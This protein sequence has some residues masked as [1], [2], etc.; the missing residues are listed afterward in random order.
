[1]CDS[2]CSRLSVY[3]CLRSLTMNSKSRIRHLEYEN[4]AHKWTQHDLTF[5]AVFNSR[6][7]RQIFACT[8]RILNIPRDEI[9]IQVYFAEPIYHENAKR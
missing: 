1:M 6:L 2:L 7:T 5:D 4:C 8:R 3:K 9:M